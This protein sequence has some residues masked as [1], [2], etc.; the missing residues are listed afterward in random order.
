MNYSIAAKPRKTAAAKEAAEPTSLADAAPLARAE[1]EEVELEEVL[2]LEL[3]PVS[4]F[5]LGV[6]VAAEALVVA[7]TKPVLAVPE[8]VAVP[9][10]CDSA[11]EVMTTLCP[12]EEQMLEKAFSATWELEP[13]VLLIVV[14]TFPALTPQMVARSAGLV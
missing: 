14:S 13:Q 7:V 9:E 1:P 8:V 4:D 12:A 2:V 6:P 10:V 3:D 5:E 11:L